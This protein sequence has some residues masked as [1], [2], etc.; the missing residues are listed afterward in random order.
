MDGE[1]PTYLF[2]DTKH[3]RVSCPL[4]LQAVVTVRSSYVQPFFLYGC[5]RTMRAYR[6]LTISDMCHNGTFELT[7]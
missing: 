7:I 1:L 2:L 6:N 5:I 3:T 4:R